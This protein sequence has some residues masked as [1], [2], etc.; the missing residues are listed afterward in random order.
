MSG[1]DYNKYVAK[2]QR[3]KRTSLVVKV[4]VGKAYNAVGFKN[5]EG[6]VR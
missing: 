2:R 4:D 3:I 5:E 1:R 6:A